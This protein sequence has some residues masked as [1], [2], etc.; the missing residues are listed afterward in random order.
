MSLSE[1]CWLWT[2]GHFPNGYGQ[3][4]KHA[5][6]RKPN[7]RYGRPIQAHRLI[8]ELFRGP[9]PPGKHLDHLCRQR[10]CVNPHHLRVVS[11]RENIL[12][13]G[14]KC[15]A[16]KNAAKTVCH[17]GHPL[18]G[19]NVYDWRGKRFCRTCKSEQKRNR[20]NSLTVKEI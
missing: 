18:T 20:R 7:G 8:Y 17:R 2:R 12:A 13:D 10:G 3:A 16:K 14:S 5:P 11:A 19:D 1:S 9:V 4:W 6:R 15:L